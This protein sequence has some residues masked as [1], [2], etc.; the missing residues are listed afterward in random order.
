MPLWIAGAVIGGAIIGGAASAGG[1][2]IAAGGAEATNAATIAADKDMQKSAQDYQTQSQATA[3]AFDERMSDTAMQRRVDDLKAAGLN[4]MLAV[5][6]GGA[7]APTISGQSS[8]SG[9]VNLQNPD[10][11][12]AN[13]GAGV[14][15]GA[16]TGLEAFQLASQFKTQSAQQD[17]MRAQAADTNA[18]AQ[19]KQA[20]IPWSGFSA[21]ASLDTQYANLEKLNNE[22]GSAFYDFKLTD[23]TYGQKLGQLRDNMDFQRRMNELSKQK[24]AIDVQRAALGLPALEND[25]AFQRSPAGRLLG[26]LFP[27]G[28]GAGVTNAAGTAGRLLQ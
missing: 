13:L 5:S 17:L 9:T 7:S 8:P 22:A 18:S 15:G 10:A 4:P 12:Y 6:S 23:E 3:M 14:S 16:S 26:P 1:A 19:L 25:A 11:G 28:V 20:Q 21:K 2:S 27:G 24:A